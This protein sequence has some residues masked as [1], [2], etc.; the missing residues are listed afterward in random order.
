MYLQTNG[1]F[2]ARLGLD[3]LESPGLQPGRVPWD[4]VRKVA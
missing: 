2:P 3:Q 1:I 4:K